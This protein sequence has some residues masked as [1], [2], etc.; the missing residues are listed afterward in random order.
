MS[1]MIIYQRDLATIS[2]KQNLNTIHKHQ[3]LDASYLLD[4]SGLKTYQSKMNKKISSMFTEDLTQNIHGYNS[5][6][7]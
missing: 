2:I 3:K 1:Q 4:T 6:N 7:L 5:L